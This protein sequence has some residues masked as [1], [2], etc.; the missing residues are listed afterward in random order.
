MMKIMVMRIFWLQLKKPRTR[1][2][3]K[4]HV[5]AFPT[6][7]FTRQPGTPS[8]TIPYCEVLC[9]RKGREEGEVAI[10]PTKL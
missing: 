9:L 5:V 10:Q 7:L 3:N 8:F 6:K 4:D 2:A 1:L